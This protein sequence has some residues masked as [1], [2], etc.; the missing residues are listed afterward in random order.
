MTQNEFNISDIIDKRPL[1]GLSLLVCVLCFFGQVSDGYDLGVVGLTAPGVIAEFH[2]TRAHM[3]PAFSAAI[4]G[5]LL[6]AIGGGYLGD[7]H[8]R[9]IG[10]LVAQMIFGLGSLA[11]SQITSINELIGLRFFV[12]IGLGAML[13]NVAAMMVEYTP[14]KI[15]ATL[16][17]ISFMGV[18]AGGALAG[19]ISAH[20][21]SPPWRLLYVIGAVIPLSMIPIIALLMPESMKYLA[22]HGKNQVG[23]MRIVQRL[24]GTVTIPHDVKLVIDEHHHG[25]GRIADLFAHKRRIMT[26]LLW[27]GFM[28][29]MFSNFY[30]NS[31][32]AVGL[33]SL[34]L[35]PEA[36]DASAS[37]YYIG[38]VFGGIAVGVGLDA[39]GA[40]ALVLALGFGIVSAIVMATQNLAIGGVQI[41]IFVYGFAVLGSQV[42]FSALGGL[43]YSTSIRSKGAGFAQGIGRLGGFVGPLAA[44]MLSQSHDFKSV[45]GFAG[46]PMA[47]AALACLV[48]TWIWSGRLMGR[49]MTELEQ[50][51]K[52]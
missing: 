41:L 33:R 37:Y 14:A 49:R 45:F 35:P 50:A 10:I 46:L 22:V 36:A 3:A 44:G 30:I 16:T 4:L 38:G 12:G 51:S 47:V 31:W 52:A 2:I 23:L 11:C 13:P 34:G 9:K 26:P 1:R 15:R 6:G 8:G 32:L 21:H 5:M 28:G 29:V 25:R 27:L 18:T 17:T 7:R 40:I 24:A 39:L 19:Q 48:L 20:L 43:L 42:G